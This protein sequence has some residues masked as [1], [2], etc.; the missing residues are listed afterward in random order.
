[1]VTRQV[2]I[3]R[4][5]VIMIDIEAA[6]NDL[7]KLADTLPYS[8]F[9]VYEGDSDHIAG[10]VY[11]KDLIH[12]LANHQETVSIRDLIR[13]AI[14]VP[15][16]LPVDQLLARFRA[17]RQH[18][19]VVLDEYGGTAGI[20][21]LDDLLEEL[22]GEVQDQFEENE[23]PEI[24]RLS[25]GSAVVSGLALISE[26]NEAFKLHITDENYDTIAGF[27]MGQLERIPVPG[28]TIELDGIVMRVQSM[29]DLRIDRLAILPKISE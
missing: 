23:Q 19:A 12:V 10:V 15:E 6:I 16:T 28:D 21:T 4:T 2:M 25:D 18:I 7:V 11:V 3:P 29:D 5:E 13:E 27:V 14:F 1:M 17:Q 8:K 20:A 9:P 24:Q 26:V 22:V